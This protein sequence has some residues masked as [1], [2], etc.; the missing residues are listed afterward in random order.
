[1]MVSKEF[2]AAQQK[3]KAE[4]ENAA[5]FLEQAMNPGGPPIGETD[6]SMMEKVHASINRAGFHS[7]EALKMSKPKQEKEQI[8]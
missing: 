6:Y 8:G 1:M 7:Y 4:L 3:L 5:L 2:F